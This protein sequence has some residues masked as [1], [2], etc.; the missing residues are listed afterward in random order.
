MDAGITAPGTA[1]AHGMDD[2]SKVRLGMRFYVITDIIFV[3]FLLVSYIWLRAYNTLG[4][5]F[6]SGTK[7]PDQTP[8]NILTALIV[9][10][11]ISYFIAYLGIRQNNQAVLRIGLLVALL[12]VIVTLVGQIRFMGS[13][14]FVATAGSYASTYILLSGYHV[15]HLLV[16][17]FLGLG[18]T[19]RALRGRYSGERMLGVTTVGYY[20]YWMALMPVLVWLMIL[21][22]PPKV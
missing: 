4:N 7:T 17:L 13:L 18:L 21:A 1:V 22:L 11:A 3:S 12:L 19:N 8:V 6:P 15:Y 5:W 20:W 10:S 2:E 14:P 16:G 9:V